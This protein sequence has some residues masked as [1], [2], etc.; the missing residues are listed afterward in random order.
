MA[1]MVLATLNGQFDII[2]PMHR[3]QRPEWYT[4]EGWEKKRLATM[5]EYISARDD[6]MVF[7][8][9]AE[10]GEMPALCSLWGADVVLFE[11]NAKVWPNIRAIWDANGL[12]PPAGYFVG[13]ASN[14]TEED[15]PNLD[16]EVGD[17]DGWPVCAYGPVIGDH[18]FRELYQ[19]SSAVPQ[20]KIDDYVKRT[21]LVPTIITFDC[22]GSDWQVMRGAENTVREHKPLIIGS[23]HPEFMFHQYGEYAAEFRRWIKDFGY[24]E[25][26]LDYQHELHVLYTPE[27]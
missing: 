22:E 18:G 26:I 21:G 25:T 1:E 10:E 12:I 13:F 15:P 2:L 6:H 16:F 23:V 7:Y 9:G 19:E 17:R 5:Y 24:R 8:V 11:P 3:A 27:V 14:S 20:I 4:P